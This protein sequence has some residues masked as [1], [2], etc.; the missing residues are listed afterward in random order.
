MQKEPRAARQSA[1]SICNGNGFRRDGDNVQ[2]VSNR[3]YLQRFPVDPVCLPVLWLLSSLLCW[4][5]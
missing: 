3:S 4:T 5:A 2:P 1:R